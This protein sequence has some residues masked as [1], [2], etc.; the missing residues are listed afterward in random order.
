MLAAALASVRGATLGQ[1][2]SES[3]SE[4]GSP[5]AF[6]LAQAPVAPLPDYAPSPSAEL[7]QLEVLPAVQVTHPGFEIPEELELVA[8]SAHVLESTCDEHPDL[9]S[10][11]LENTACFA[12]LGSSFLQRAQDVEFVLGS[13]ELSLYH[14]NR[15]SVICLHVMLRSSHKENFYYSCS[16]LAPSP[17]GY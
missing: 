16:V 8:A 15:D 4:E 5:C 11:Y 1:H 10:H 6:L 3:P 17:L 13:W 9:G 14:V 7:L 2:A 12:G